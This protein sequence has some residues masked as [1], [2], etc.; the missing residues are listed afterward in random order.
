MLQNIIKTMSLLFF[1]T[2]I[3]CACEPKKELPKEAL[4][5][6]KRKMGGFFQSL[7]DVSPGVKDS[8]ATLQARNGFC[9]SLRDTHLRYLTQCAQYKGSDKLEKLKQITDATKMS[10]ETMIVIWDEL[11]LEN[12][13]LQ[14]VNELFEQK[15]LLQSKHANS[16]KS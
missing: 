10:F 4:E 12:D 5:M 14:K 1:I 2:Q 16:T 15:K 3:C 9:Q 11:I 6:Q 13:K 7:K 8:N